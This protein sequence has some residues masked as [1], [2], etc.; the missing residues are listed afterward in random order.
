MKK[1][2]GPQLPDE[3]TAK[4]DSTRWMPTLICVLPGRTDQIVVLSCAGS[5]RIAD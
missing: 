3:R 4:T 5:T 1:T 2:L